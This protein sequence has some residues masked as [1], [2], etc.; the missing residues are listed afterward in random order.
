[1]IDNNTIIICIFILTIINSLYIGYVLGKK[2][3]SNK[4]QTTPT[5]S[6]FEKE[7]IEHNKKSISIDDTKFVGN[8]RTEG[9]EKKYENLGETKKS[10]EN[11]SGAI[12]KLKNMKG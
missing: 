8:I 7:K 2:C 9:L 12:N 10:S 4:H 1:M 6:F 5:K 11:I 3:S